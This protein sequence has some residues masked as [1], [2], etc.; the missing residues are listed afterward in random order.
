[1]RH[2]PVEIAAAVYPTVA[3]GKKR[4]SGGTTFENARNFPATFTFHLAMQK[5]K[6]PI[7]C[8]CRLPYDKEEYVQCCKYH[9]CY[10]IGCVKVPEWAVVMYGSVGLCIVK[11]GN[12]GLCMA[13]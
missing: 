11:Y 12:V 4:E 6:V 1:M 2:P 13:V 10:H 9:A 7:F 8:I 3:R 5:T